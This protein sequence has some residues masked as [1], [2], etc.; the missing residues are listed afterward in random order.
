[1]AER[2]RAQVELGRLNLELEQR[3]K[4]GTAE[5]HESRSAVVQYPGHIPL[6]QL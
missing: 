3:V 6:S 1:L 2:Q 5:L 4:A